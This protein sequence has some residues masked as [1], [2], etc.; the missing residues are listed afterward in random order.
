MEIEVI[1]LDSI[2]IRISQEPASKVV[3]LGGVKVTMDPKV[4]VT[5]PKGPENE[6]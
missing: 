2:P 6:H 1:E 4:G 3:G 5:T